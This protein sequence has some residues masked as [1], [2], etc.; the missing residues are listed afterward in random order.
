MRN[1]IFRRLATVLLFVL[2]TATGARAQQNN[3][4]AD[5]KAIVA[6]GQ[7]R[8]TVLTPQL[9]RM[10]WAADGKFEDRASL[11]FINRRLAAPGFD[12]DFDGE[13]LVLRTNKLLL[14]YKRSSGRFSPENLEISLTLNGRQV[15][16]RPGAPD[17][18]NLGGTIRTLDGVKG[19]TPLEPGILSRDGWVLVDDTA[20]PLLNNSDWPW[21]MPRPAGERQDWY[22]FGYG[23]DYKAALAD[24]T[25]VAGKIPLPPRFAFGL[26]WSRYWA[27]TDVEFKQL[28]EEFESHNV[29]LDVLVI[30]MDW[31][32]TFGVK[33]W[34]NKLD[35]AG[36]RLGWSGYTWSKMYF[37]DPEGFLKWTDRRGLQTPLNVHPASGV[38][39]HEERY[40]EMARAMGID[41]ATKKHVPFD[42]ADKKFAGNYMKILHH[43]LEA[44]GVDFWWLDW[45]QHHTTSVE[46]LTPTWWLN[47]VHFT[48]M[49]R[50]GKRPLLF[51]RW[52][53]LGNHRYQIGFSG[54]TISTW[55]SLAF[56]PYFT[57]T[58]ANVGYGYWS[59]DIGG[60]M[61]ARLGGK[62]VTGPPDPDYPELYTRWIQYG[63][64]SPV[65]RT[66]TTKDPNS[67]RR[68]WAYPAE[69][70]RV[71][72]DAVLL[73]YSLIPYIYTESRK[74]Y[75]TGISLC[76]PMYYEYPEAAEAYQ[77]KDQYFFGDDLLIA[78]IASALSPE[79]ALAAK[80]VWLPA[81]AWYEW[82]SGAL[83]EGGRKIQRQF[84]LDEIP[85]YARAGAVIPMQPS[86][87][88]AG[89]GS[90]RKLILTIFPGDAGS[91]R[92]YED[93]GNS[94]GYKSGEF[95]WATV[96]HSTA[97]NGARRIEILPAEGKY[98]GMPAA[99]SF[100]IRLA[101]S[102]PPA[103]VRFNGAAVS[104]S[105]D[106]AAAPAWRYDGDRATV[107]ISV[108]ESP[109]ASK[110]EVVVQPA[111]FDAAQHRLLNGLPQ[112]LTRLLAAMNTLNHSWPQGWS[113]D[114][115]IEAAQTG[116]RISINPKVAV[117]EVTRLRRQLPGVIAE[118]EKMDVAPEMRDRALAQLK[119]IL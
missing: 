65:L 90:P 111:P 86:V 59:H 23:H 116:N 7:A 38:Q 37:P 11:V 35:Q 66:H 5:P 14:R 67:E 17:A 1:H 83:L 9:I 15:T 112:I 89:Q 44:Q 2:L 8:F 94:L 113:P 43:P 68:I 75:D 3:P 99:R 51:H 30:D 106:T 24:F 97:A 26:W 31:H 79:S 50:R 110:V 39:P 88:R 60:H 63:A 4:L 109:A 19:D 61:R 84:A 45:Q 87:W 74:S 6:S 41:P 29:P 77:F 47:Y 108:P 20:R 70:A 103:S 27:Y 56:Q 118:I 53:G 55:D 71:M 12:S 92:V 54:D 82:P 48:D 52:G 107:I 101:A 115:L 76:R 69:Y 18:G 36:Q 98:P 33:W 25:R 105:R 117:E 104:F 22:F 114:S 40:P 91:A 95:S 64:F 16:W 72:R 80:S 34:E 119:S 57:A 28:V 13:W 46:G 58:A 21:A 93:E 85:A 81:G 42:I 100:E 49:E 10:E 62:P 73:R 96:R 78:P 102:W 32:P